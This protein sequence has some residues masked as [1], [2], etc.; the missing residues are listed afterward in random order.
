MWSFR[1]EKSQPSHPQF[2]LSANWR[3][4]GHSLS[5]SIGGMDE[6]LTNPNLLVSDENEPK[7]P[8]SVL[9]IKCIPTF[10]IPCYHLD[11]VH[12]QCEK[13]SNFYLQKNVWGPERSK[14]K[15]SNSWITGKYDSQ[16]F[17]AAE[18]VSCPQHK[19][20]WTLA[21]GGW[22]VVETSESCWPLLTSPG[23]PHPFL[24]SFASPTSYLACFAINKENISPCLD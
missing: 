14:K 21:P 22:R 4:E 11:K 10:T 20:R 24:R 19:Q 16:K 12:C 17:P 7:P 23:P 6:N 5:S 1:G 15:E 2:L 13:G 9:W 8:T 18:K 3:T